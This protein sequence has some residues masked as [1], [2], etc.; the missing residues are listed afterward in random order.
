MDGRRVAMASAAADAGGT[1]SNVQSGSGVEM[2]AIH[3]HSWECVKVR[4]GAACD[5]SGVVAATNDACGVLGECM[6][7]L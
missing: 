1:A 5:R 7:I 6:H 2:A 4:R 3:R